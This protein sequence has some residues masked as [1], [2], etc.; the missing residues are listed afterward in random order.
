MTPLFEYQSIN[1][2]LQK[3]SGGGFN[4]IGFGLHFLGKRY[5]LKL[6]G[7]TELVFAT[8]THALSAPSRGETLE[9]A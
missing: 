7:D 1:K 2:S 3:T 4:F 5:D 6:R 8:V 9:T